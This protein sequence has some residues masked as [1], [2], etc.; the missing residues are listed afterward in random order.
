MKVNV[1]LQD[2]LVSRI[3]NFADENYMSRSGFLTLAA[4]QYL[5]TQD[6]MRLIRD[7]SLAMRKI[8]DTGT[9]DPEVMSQLEDFERFSK[10]LIGQK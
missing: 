6:T 2:E 4:V 8:A 5:N 9:V 1:T 10:M 7:M 3:D